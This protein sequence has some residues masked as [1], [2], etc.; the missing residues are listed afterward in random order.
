MLRAFSAKVAET[1]DG[2]VIEG[3]TRLPPG[4]VGSDGDHR[5]AIKG[6]DAVATRY[7]QFADQ[8]VTLTDARCEPGV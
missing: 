4:S 7:P 3:G 8:L 5:I 1:E 2:L 6:W